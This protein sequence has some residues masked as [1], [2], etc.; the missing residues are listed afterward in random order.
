MERYSRNILI[1][2]VGEEGQQKLLCSKVLVA[3]AGGLGSSVIASLA[4]MGIGTLGLIDND[5]VELSNLNRQFIHKFENIG[6]AKVISAKE[7]INNY[8]PDIIVDTYQVRLDESNCDEIINKYDVIVD[9]FDSYKS[10]F[11]LNKACIENNKIFVHGGV[12]EFFGQVM[13]IIPG[14]S[15]CL[16]CIFDKV[17][18]DYGIKGI[19]SPTVNVI[20]SLQ[21]MEV[22]KIIL[23][24]NSVLTYTFLSYD[25]INQRFK[26]ITVNKNLNCS[27][28]G[29]KSPL[30][31]KN[32]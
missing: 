11:M 32:I 15:P 7:W 10:K 30:T 6:K 1:E 26:N 8:N 17:D 14:K 25:G 29:I 9:C 20:G 16:N 24:I 31:S 18:T 19:I 28:C 13:T 2:K 22:L 23:N 27:V 4:S 5:Q 21:S 12:T 3:G